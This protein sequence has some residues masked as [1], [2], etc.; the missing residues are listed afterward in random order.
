MKL[1]LVKIENYNDKENF[2]PE[3]PNWESCSENYS[4]DSVFDE[5]S[6]KRIKISNSVDLLNDVDSAMSNLRSVLEEN[7]DD[8][9][10]VKNV[11]K[12][13]STLL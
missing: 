7:I 10:V 11:T 13:L 6:K 4:D 3:T 12:F 9:Y 2:A 8:E 1:L 5:P